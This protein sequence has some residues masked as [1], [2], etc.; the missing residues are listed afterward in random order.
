MPPY[1]L[2]SS[3]PRTSSARHPSDP[4]RPASTDP[5]LPLLSALLLGVAL[6]LVLFSLALLF[7]IGG[8]LIRYWDFALE[9]AGSE[10]R[11]RY[12]AF[13]QREVTVPLARVQALRIE[14]S[15][16]RRPLGL[17]LAQ[18]RDRWCAPGKAGRG[19]AEAFLLWSA[20]VRCRGSPAQSST[21]STTATSF[22]AP[23]TRTPGRAPFS[24]TA[25]SCS[26]LAT[27]A[28]VRLGAAALWFLLLLILAYVAA[29]AHY[30]ALAYA[31]APGY[32]VARSGF[33]NRITWIVPE[34]KVQ[35][36]H[37]VETLFR[38]AA[39]RNP[40]GGY[41][42]GAGACRESRL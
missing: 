34:R 36:V 12:G 18:D 39:G 14:E 32:L 15:L 8:A 38:A 22:F 42:R 30:R 7:S 19:G 6:L 2:A 37:L 41:R 28:A 31:R 23:H 3:K 13:D 35:T 1:L 26:P 40:C 5:D 11:K 33:W 16:L 10:L 17:A 29:H 20:S 24:G 27:G 21:G 25:H 9:R 4:A